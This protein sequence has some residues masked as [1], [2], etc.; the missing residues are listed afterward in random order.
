MR[1]LGLKRW[2]LLMAAVVLQTGLAWAAKEGR[3]GG[4]RASSFCIVY[5]GK[6]EAEEGILRA[7]ELQHA[8]ETD[9]GTRLEVRPDSSFGQGNAIVL[10]R[11]SD[12]PFDYEISEQTGRLTIKG[13]GAWALQAATAKVA[14]ALTNGIP[15]GWKVSGTVAGEQIFP[16]EGANLRIMDDNIWNNLGLATIPAKWEK[17][18]ADPRDAARAPLF[19]Q[20]VRAYMPDVVCLQEYAPEMHALLSP[21]L[22]DYGYEIIREDDKC[23]TPIFYRTETLEPMHTTFCRFG[24]K[25]WCDYDSKSYTAAVLRHKETGRVF[26]CVTTHLMCST[27]AKSPGTTQAR[28]A[29]SR[30]ILAETEGIGARFD[31]PIFVMGDMNCYESD[32]PMQQFFEAGYM[33]C[34]KLATVRTNYDNGHHV[35]NAS[36]GFSRR[37]KRP[38]PM[39][40][41]GA[42]DHV[43]LLDKQQ[44]V[45]VKVFDCIQARFTL[46]LTDHYP[47]VVDVLLK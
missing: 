22:R 44:N 27:D 47:N 41:R 10:Q 9:F 13:G 12:G 6:A 3:I 14:A 39:R 18:G 2:W 15:K 42:L 23:Y 34:Y 36:A 30:L 19:A 29:Q 31:C 24:P 20:L 25:Q 32:V 38:S 8:I 37:S 33:P 7:Q 26:A 35:C 1:N 28:A 21:L 11:G 5:R 16:L 4:R 45:E 17:R 43:L 40:E 46:S